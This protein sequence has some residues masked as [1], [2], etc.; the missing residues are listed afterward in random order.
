[1]PIFEFRCRKC[2]H[3]LETITS[4]SEDGSGITCPVCGQKGM[5]KL[6]SIFSSSGTSAP[7]G[8]G[9]CGHNHSGGFS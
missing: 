7:V 3:Q 4:A 2:S 5:E 6:L 9:G 8:G 1:M